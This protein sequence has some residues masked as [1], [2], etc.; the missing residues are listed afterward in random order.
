MNYSDYHTHPINKLIHF[1]CIPFIVLTTINFLSLIKKKFFNL[2]IY[3]VLLNLLLINYLVNY[4][5]LAFLVMSIYYFAAL[6]ISFNWRFR[7]NWINES[8]L[9]FILSWT[10]Q[11]LGH[12]IEGNRPALFTS[13]SQS[14][15]Q[16]PL[17]SIS[18]IIPF[19][20]E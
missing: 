14:I 20:I 15:S 16:A 18:Y 5:F 17:F 6:L 1:I 4:S 11:F 8:I 9:I 2:E 3:E 10:F 19:S 12:Y 7:P 13:L